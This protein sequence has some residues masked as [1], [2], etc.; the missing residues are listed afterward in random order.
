M[1][2][3]NTNTEIWATL[4]ILISIHLTTNY[5]AVRSVIMET[6]NR[7]RT[8]AVFAYL[9]EKTSPLMMESDLVDCEAVLPS[10]IL[11]PNEVARQ[12]RVLESDGLLRWGS[13]GPVLGY[14][15]IGSFSAVCRMLPSE[16]SVRELLHLFDDARAGYVLWFEHGRVRGR[17]GSYVT[18]RG[19]LVDFGHPHDDD[20]ENYDAKP[21]VNS[22]TETV[23]TR[24]LRAW[25]HAL[26]LAKS[27]RAL[28]HGSGEVASLTAAREHVSRTLRIVDA[29]FSDGAAAEALRIRGWDLTRGR[30]MVVSGSAPRVRVHGHVTSG[31]R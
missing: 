26:Y 16:M 18:V 19:A 4:L 27:V 10:R 24:E 2:F 12:E 5:W 3:V 25:V 14:A 28:H 1:P 30:T 17:K 20:S 22:A 23:D 13:T 31:E 11:S 15:S 7:Q 21:D 29:L 8:N 6:L 9:M